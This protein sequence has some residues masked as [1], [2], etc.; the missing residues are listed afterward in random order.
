MDSIIMGANWFVAELNQRLRI[1]TL[2]LP[3]LKKKMEEMTPGGGFMS[4]DVPGEVEPLEAPFALNGS[5]ADIRSLFGREPGDWTNFFYYE[6]LRDFRAGRN[7]GRVTHLRGLVN[8]VEQPEVKGKKGESAKY[9]V[10]TI[11]LYRDIV[12]GRLVHLFDYFNNRLVI[13][14]Q[15]YT[16]EA[17]R[18]IAA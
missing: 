4:L 18:L 14:G 2:Q 13:N 1:D 16:A 17:N 11:V 7:L 8:E 10:G 15:D 3:A 5:H 9:K 12:D 6:R